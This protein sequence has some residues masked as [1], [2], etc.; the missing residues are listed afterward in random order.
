LLPSAISQRLGHIHIPSRTIPFL[1]LTVASIDPTLSF[2]DSGHYMQF[3]RMNFRHHI[4]KLTSAF[5]HPFYI[6]TCSQVV[7]Y[8]TRFETSHRSRFQVYQDDY[9]SYSENHV[10]TPSTMQ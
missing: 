2:P 9:R 8:N 10:H 7:V 6:P 3:R 1:V 5:F 4:R